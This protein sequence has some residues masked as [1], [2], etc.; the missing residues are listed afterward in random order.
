MAKPYRTGDPVIYRKLKHS[1]HPGERAKNVEPAPNGDYYT[2]EVDKF[3][4]V[5]DLTEDGKLVLVTRR[6][7]K[8][9]ISP[10]DPNVRRANLWERFLY[11]DRFP[12]IPE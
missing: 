12:P 2:Y 3:W 1:V 9:V 7:K 11:A 10:N 8:H 5:A 4:T 6:G